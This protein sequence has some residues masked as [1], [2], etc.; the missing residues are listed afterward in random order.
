MPLQNAN[1]T[2]KKREAEKEKNT[3]GLTVEVII[4][5]IFLACLA[6][7]IILTFTHAILESIEE[8]LELIFDEIGKSGRDNK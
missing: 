1:K 7:V 8:W 6:A 4:F 3:G 5:L 2:E